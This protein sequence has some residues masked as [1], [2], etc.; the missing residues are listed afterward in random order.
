V[1]ERARGFKMPILYCNRHRLPPELE[2]G[3]RYFPTLTSMLPECDILSLHAPSAAAT[4]RI[5]DAPALA[6]LPDGAILVN[7]ARGQLVD[8]T[9]LL[10]ALQTRHLF[11]AGLD[12]FHEEPDFDRRFAAL[13]NV[14]LTPHI[15]SATLETRTAMAMRAL[16]NV[17]ALCNGRPAIDALC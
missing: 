15:G 2:Q 13:P 6:L 17:A 3:A 7:T 11:A 8:E 4:D 1:A 10:A 9:A 16:D 12:V 5:I 14:F